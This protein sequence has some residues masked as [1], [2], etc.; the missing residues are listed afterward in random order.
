M[1]NR[2]FEGLTESDRQKNSGPRAWI[3]AVVIQTP[4]RQR[5]SGRNFRRRLMEPPEIMNSPS[6][7]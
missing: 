2:R 5:L 6:P 3:T 4:V 1:P 7:R